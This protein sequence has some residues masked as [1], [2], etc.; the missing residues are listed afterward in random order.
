V[1]SLIYEAERRIDVAWEREAGETPG[2]AVKLV[3]Y[4]DDRFGMLKQITAV[5]SDARTNIRHIEAQTSNAQASIEIVMDI[6]DL[7]HLENIV[8]GLRKIPGVH[9][10]QRHQKL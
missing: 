1:T 4:C 9:E 2:Y 8:A 6:A 5:I 7:K 10:V 3:V